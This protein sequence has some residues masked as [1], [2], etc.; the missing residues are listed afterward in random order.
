MCSVLIWPG[1]TPAEDQLIYNH[2]ADPGFD[3]DALKIHSDLGQ[4]LRT[5]MREH[6]TPAA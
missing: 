2:V 1:T 5:M 6:G 4:R 3:Y